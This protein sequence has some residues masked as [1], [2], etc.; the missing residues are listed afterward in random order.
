MNI[1][2]I[3]IFVMVLLVGLPFVVA[4]D[5]D[6]SC[7]ENNPSSKP[8]D[9]ILYQNFS[10]YDAL[11]KSLWITLGEIDYN[12]SDD[13][14]N[15]SERPG[16][17]TWQ[18]VIHSGNH[19]PNITKGM[20]VDVQFSPH[21]I[22]NL[23]EYGFLI[24]FQD[25]FTGPSYVNDG[26]DIQFG[27]E[28][29]NQ[30]EIRQENAPINPEWFNF[31]FGQTYNITM[32][33]DSN[34]DSNVY[35]FY[36][37]NS[38]EQVINASGLA[39]E[40]SIALLPRADS[41]VRI[42]FIKVYNQTLG[43]PGIVPELVH[44]SGS[45]FNT[46]NI[47]IFNEESVND[48]LVADFNSNFVTYTSDPERITNYTFNFNNSNKYNI[49]LSTME[50]DDILTVDADIFYN[51]T[52]GY[53]QRWFLRNLELNGGET[54]LLNLYNFNSQ[55]G[56]DEL[57]GVVRDSTYAFFSNVIAELQRYYP[58]ENLWRAVQMDKSDDFG[59]VVFHIH[60]ADTDYRL[61][62]TQGNNLIE[63]TNP[64][65]FTCDTND[66]CEVTF[67][68][69]NSLAITQEKFTSSS[70]Y[71]N[72]TE[73]FELNFSDTTGITTN[74][75]LRVTKET[76]TQ[77]TEICDISLSSSSGTLSCNTTGYDGLLRAWVFT[78]QS[79]ES[80]QEIIWI[81]KT[82]NKLFQAAGLVST[83]GVFWATG[84]VSTVIIAGTIISPVFG[85]LFTVAGLTITYWLGVV[86]FITV[87]FIVLV[88]VLAIVVSMLLKEGR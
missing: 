19:S 54:Q 18:G 53:N 58:S 16:G 23:S 14:L 29:Q 67:L 51:T 81:T 41:E 32:C 31:S 66:I 55:V 78:T 17:N 47:S 37:N 85:I 63:E 76:G 70:A 49:C 26:E 68:L 79:P 34:T 28:I 11:N 86:N 48:G 15:F 62:F 69:D 50:S 36:I 13:Y 6:I 45:D 38:N 52:G 82:V 60:E 40:T 64:L 33:F 21:K 5:Y 4:D 43:C 88:A 35:K 56:L 9:Y 65:K 7:F 27:S 87:T 46:L 42:N 80:P 61:R 39:N 2:N 25:Q 84:I 1:K 10:E 75:R 83:E 59:S 22:E 73:M 74:V 12:V 30:T 71:N 44:C 57:R 72:I 24:G 20:C 3:L 77:Q 8:S